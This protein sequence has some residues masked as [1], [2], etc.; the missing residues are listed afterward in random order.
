MGEDEREIYRRFDHWK[1]MLQES[2]GSGGLAG[3]SS[4]TEEGC[5][6]VLLDSRTRIG[7]E[8]RDVVVERLT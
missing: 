4:T 3:G 6:D 8:E 1:I 5:V 7:D 2:G